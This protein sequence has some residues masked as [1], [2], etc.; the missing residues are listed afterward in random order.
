[1][2]HISP[3]SDQLDFLLHIIEERII[4][5]MQVELC[6]KGGKSCKKEWKESHLVKIILL[7]LAPDTRFPRTTISFSSKKIVIEEEL[8]MQSYG[9]C[10]IHSVGISA[11]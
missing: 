8:E 3:V 5:A 10:M 4:P 1:M 2:V 6:C 7:L 9:C 11:R